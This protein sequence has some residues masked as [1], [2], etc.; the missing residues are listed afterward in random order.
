MRG[1]RWLRVGER[2]RLAPAR[3]PAFPSPAAA[4][5]VPALGPGCSLRGR[6]AGGRSGCQ[7]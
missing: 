5:A 6:K 2:L 3:A 4:P 7:E 1:G